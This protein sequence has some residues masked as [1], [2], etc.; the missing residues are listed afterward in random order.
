MSGKFSQNLINRL[1]IYIEEKHRISLT[2]EQAESYLNSLADFFIWLNKR[3]EENH[4]L[5]EQK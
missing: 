5:R 3:R 1:I 2:L 4:S